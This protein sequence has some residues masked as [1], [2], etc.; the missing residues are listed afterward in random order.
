[1][2]GMNKANQYPLVETS[3][4]WPKKENDKDD[5]EYEVPILKYDAN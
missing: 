1:M 3:H 4:K 5:N 2:L